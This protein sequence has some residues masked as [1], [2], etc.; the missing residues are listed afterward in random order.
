MGNAKIWFYPS[1][2]GGMVEID[3]GE[4][5]SDWQETPDVRAG[6]SSFQGD[7]D[8][9]RI[10]YGGRSQVRILNER[11]GDEDLAAKLFSLESH[12]KKGKPISFAA[13]STKCYAAFLEEYTPTAGLSALQVKGNMFWVYE[14]VDTPPTGGPD[15]YVIRSQNPDGK[16]EMVKSSSYDSDLDEIQIVNTTIYD[17]TRGPVFIRHRYFYPIVRLNPSYFERPLL[18][19]DRAMNWTFDCSLFESP[20]DYA[21]LYA[22]TGGEGGAVEIGLAPA[23]VGVF[24]GAG[25]AAGGMESEGYQTLDQ[26]LTGG[27]MVAFD[28][29]SPYDIDDRFY[30]TDFLSTPGT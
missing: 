20:G 6:E 28:G 30:D 10:D 14:E 26:L 13:D 15:Y 21:K 17:H 2:D 23:E 4:G 24:Y 8:T 12:L 11:F 22:A 16:T 29:T 19:G 3:F 25:G 27:G 7:Y 18:T 1:E 5:L 9:S